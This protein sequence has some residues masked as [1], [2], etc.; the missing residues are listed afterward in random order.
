MSYS[1]SPIS[2]RIF[3]PFLPI[4]FWKALHLL[5]RW[6]RSG[7]SRAKRSPHLSGSKRPWD[8]GITGVL[9]LCQGHSGCLGERSLWLPLCHHAPPQEGCPLK[10]RAVLGKPLPL[11]WLSRTDRLAF[12]KVPTKGNHGN[13]ETEW[14][15]SHSSR[16]LSHSSSERIHQIQMTKTTLWPPDVPALSR[17]HVKGAS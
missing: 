7:S 1:N 16:G 3:P 13:T 4:P 12:L 2:T 6:K 14:S 17:G 5:G 11:L 10:G 15:L 8:Q 9:T